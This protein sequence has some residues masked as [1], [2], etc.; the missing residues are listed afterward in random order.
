MVRFGET[1]EQTQ[2]APLFT[3]KNKSNYN[4]FLKKHKNEAR[5]Y[6]FIIC[7]YSFPSST[8]DIKYSTPSNLT[9]SAPKVASLAETESLANASFRCPALADLR[10]LYT[11]L[12]SF[13]CKEEEQ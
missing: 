2:P 6:E 1:V 4:F 3:V 5:K 12:A 13:H 10:A 8:L 11:S 7:S 9:N